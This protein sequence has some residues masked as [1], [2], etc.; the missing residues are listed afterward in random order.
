PAIGEDVRAALPPLRDSLESDRWVR[1]ANDQRP[2]LKALAAATASLVEQAKTLR[3]GI[4]PHLEALASATTA[5]PN[6]R[7][8]PPRD[9]FDTTWA[10]GLQL[11]WSPTEAWASGAGRSALEAQ[12]RKAAAD[13]RQARDALGDEVV[14]AVE[15]LRSTEVAVESSTRGLRS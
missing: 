11:G 3:A 13:E 7:F 2:E 9:Q 12:A 1:R 8:F 5:N 6:P 14:S 10:L 4:Y 15:A